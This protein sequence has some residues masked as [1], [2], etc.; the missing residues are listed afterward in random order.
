MLMSISKNQ[1]N[2]NKIERESLFWEN[3]VFVKIMNFDPELD[4]DE[5]L[6][7]PYEPKA[8]DPGWK[9]TF[10]VII[11]CIS[12]NALLPIFLICA[13]RRDHLKD[14][15]WEREK[16]NLNNHGGGGDNGD[17]KSITGESNAAVSYII[18]AS[19]SAGAA[20]TVSAAK[21]I[22]ASTVI[23]E[24]ASKV[25]ES[26]RANKTHRGRHH[27]HQTKRKGTRRNHKKKTN[28]QQ[29]SSTKKVYDE[30]D[31]KSVMS[32]L[33][34]DAVS[35]SDA[36]DAQDKGTAPKPYSY[37]SSDERIPLFEKL[38]I[39]STWDKEMKKLVSLWIPYTIS[40]ASDGFFQIINVGIIS[41]FIGV[42]EAN[43]Y[44]V[45]IILVEF[46][47]TFTYGW[48][49]GMYFFVLKEN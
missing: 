44:V 17:A 25:L 26:R 4:D 42:N 23:S 35:V 31:D 5:F 43:A 45:V 49:E 8:I 32:K 37:L 47:A 9:F 12:I 7:T 1:S 20:S 28:A 18:S 46:T 33:D 13:K 2:H 22:G 36:V 34:Q 11:I 16:N 39:A 27:H 21:S 14:E 6:T 48:G 3:K 29:K 30:D 40:G 19:K 38:L 10:V 41:H 15:E 24:V